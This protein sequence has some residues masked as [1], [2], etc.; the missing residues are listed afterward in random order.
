MF[1]QAAVFNQRLRHEIIMH[2]RHVFLAHDAP[3]FAI[4]LAA[5]I[6]LGIERCPFFVIGALPHIVRV[7]ALVC[8]LREIVIAV[9]CGHQI[10]GRD[11]SEI[12]IDR[13]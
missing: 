9:A 3:V 7:F 10:L 2:L 8:K 13:G 4:V 12:E 11:F 6:P 5:V 1:D